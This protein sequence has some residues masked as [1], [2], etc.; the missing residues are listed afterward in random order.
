MYYA[1]GLHCWCCNDEVVVF[2]LLPV[3]PQ[4]PSD[5]YRV[6]KPPQTALGDNCRRPT[7]K[8]RVLSDRTGACICRSVLGFAESSSTDLLFVPKFS[9]NFVTWVFAVGLLFGI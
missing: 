2:S 1:T 7:H 3:E 4:L 5:Q 8:V 9:P 6:H